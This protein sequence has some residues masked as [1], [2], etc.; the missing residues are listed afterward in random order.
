MGKFGDFELYKSGDCVLFEL[1]TK[2]AAT[3]ASPAAQEGDLRLLLAQVNGKNTA[4]LY[5]YVVPGAPNP[6]AITSG[7][8]TLKI[9]DGRVLT[10]VKMATTTSEDGY[11]LEAAIPLATLG[12]S[13]Q[14]GAK[15]RGDFGI[16]YSD[17]EGTRNT[18]RMHWATRNT[19]LISDSNYEARIQPDQWGTFVEPEEK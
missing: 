14:A 17:A 10:D 1:G 16:I 18:L 2:R 8:G 12:F 11:T 3:D 13:P 6:V 7:L 5:R 15:Y 19:G 4:V 9:D